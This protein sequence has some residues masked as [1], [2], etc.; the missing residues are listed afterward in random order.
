MEKHPVMLAITP[1]RK[2]YMGG[3]NYYSGGYFFMDCA[4]FFGQITKENP[5]IFRFSIKLN[6]DDLKLKYKDNRPDSSGYFNKRNTVQ[7]SHST[8]R[9][10]TAVIL[11][12]VEISQGALTKFLSIRIKDSYGAF[13]PASVY[14]LNGLSEGEHTLELKFKS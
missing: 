5:S 2:D 10:L 6:E 1:P 12:G 7:F 11:D 13:Y 3:I 14:I 8:E 4:Y 9:T